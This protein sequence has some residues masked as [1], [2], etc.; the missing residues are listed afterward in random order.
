[1]KRVFLAAWALSIVLVARAQEPAAT[2]WPTKGWSTATPAQEGV[3]AKVLEA[4]D[5]EIRAGRHR[6]VDSMLVIRR[7]RIVFERYYRHDYEKATAKR[8]RSAHQYNYDH[9]NWHPYYQGSKLHTMQSVTKSVTS[10]M[11]GIALQR[12]ELKST[13]T[14]VLSFFPKRKIL[15]PDGR[16]A[17]MKLEDVLTMRAGFLW[18]EW[19][20]GLDDPT[21]DCIR[22]E[23]SDDWVEYTLN[24]PMATEPGTTFVYNSGSTHL[25]SAIIKRATGETID[26]YARKLLFE[27]LGIDSF[28][29]KKTPKGLPDTE[30]GLYLRPRDLARIGYL[31]LRDG[32]WEGQ[33]ILPE[34]WVERSV[35][36]WVADIAPAN[37]S[38][39]RG[40]GYKWWILDDGSGKR[41]KCYAAMG[42]GGQLLFVVPKLDLI[43]VFTAWNI[44]GRS[45]GLPDIFRHR[46][47]PAVGG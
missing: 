7:G 3:D 22:L 1:M 19:T 42:Y 23:S 36:P 27:P 30:G 33:R 31:Y 26:D 5:A 44:H 21:N 18:D 4:I 8:D 24:K 34:K 41:P 43:G 11:I 13:K 29:W 17:K 14:P 12:G 10:A 40:Y 16:K 39:D 35:T 6:F 9:P 46:I 47:V 15:D 2:R 45:P 28:H 20:V 32:I 38:Y 25:L 37:P